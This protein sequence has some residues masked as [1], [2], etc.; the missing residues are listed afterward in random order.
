MPVSM[1]RSGRISQISSCM[2]I[3]SWGYWMMGRPM[4]E[5]LYE[6]CSLLD[7]VLKSFSACCKPGLVPFAFTLSM[8]SFLK[9][10]IGSLIIGYHFKFCIVAPKTHRFIVGIRVIAKVQF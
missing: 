6:Y 4:Q 8:V 7:S 2:A 5:Q 10:W 3:I 9:A 1:I